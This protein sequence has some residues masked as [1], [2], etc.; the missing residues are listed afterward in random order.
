VLS[1]LHVISDI[2]KTGPIVFTFA[3]FPLISRARF[4]YYSVMSMLHC[5]LF[6]FLKFAMA[7]PRPFMLST[8]IKLIGACPTSFGNP[9]GHSITASMFGIV[10]FLDIFHGKGFEGYTQ[11]TKH[12]NG[13]Y[14]LGVLILLIWVSVIPV[15]RFI[16]GAHSLDQI[17]FGFTLG[18]WAAFVLHFLV[19]DHLYAFIC[20]EK[21]SRGFDNYRRS[22]DDIE[23]GSSQASTT[24]QEE[25]DDFLPQE[26]LRSGSH[27][28][29]L[30]GLSACFA[31]VA[32]STTAFLEAKSSFD[33]ESLPES[34]Y[35]EN[36]I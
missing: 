2:G 23:I 12:S 31:F 6:S 14:L 1:I 18:L 29:F 32:V 36:F 8:D 27:R 5:T 11:S 10:L 9:S 7:N 25:S 34:S 13:T 20:Q 30:L 19:R 21:E 33:P 26:K 17:V 15:S 28:G 16:L 4:V 3:I 35:M 24:S 22:S